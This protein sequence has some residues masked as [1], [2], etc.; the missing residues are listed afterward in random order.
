MKQHSTKAIIFATDQNK[1]EYAVA[2]IEQILYE[3]DTFDYSIKP[4]YSVISLTNS[5]FFQGIPGLNLDLK[6]DEYIRTDSV[7][8]FIYERTPQKNREDLW[9]L[10]EEVNLD[11]YNPLEWLIRSNKKYTGDHLSVKAYREPITKTIINSIQPYDSFNLHNINDIASNTFLKLKNILEI[12]VNGANLNIGNFVIDD[13][14]RLSLYTI[15]YNLY[16]NERNIRKNQQKT[17]IK[18]TI[19]A[20]KGRS[21]IKISYPK[22]VE[23]MTLYEN[24]EMSLEEA[25]KSL[26]LISE[27]TFYRRLKEFRNNYLNDIKEK[28]NQID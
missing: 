22:L 21:K 2:T 1:I 25:M 3:D 10:L 16:I 18:N 20:Y 27:A 14:N 6:N 7:P 12:I 9:Q 11:Y 24:K 5:S 13:N 15:F 8:T 23:I 28:S 19:K 17:G 26:N 4:N